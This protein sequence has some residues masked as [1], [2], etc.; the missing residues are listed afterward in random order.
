LE[1]SSC[2]RKR[3]APIRKTSKEESKRAVVGRE[4]NVII[5]D[6]YVLSMDEHQ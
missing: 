3:A 5:Y 4:L 1:E 2:L 6:L